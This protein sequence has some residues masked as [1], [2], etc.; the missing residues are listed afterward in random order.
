MTTSER[1]DPERHEAITGLFHAAL[2]RPATE[3]AGYLRLACGGDSDLYQEVMY[4][5]ALEESA[6][7]LPDWTAIVSPAGSSH[8]PDGER[9]KC[10]PRCQRQFPATFRLCPDDEQRLSLQ[11]PYH[12]VGRTLADKFLIEALI[13]I[14]GMG[15]V[16]S[17]LHLG[18][19]RRVAFKILQPNVALG[20]ERM[21]SLFEREAK[22][23]GHLSHENIADITDAGRTADGIAYLVMEWLDGNTLD[24]ELAAS[25]PLSLERTAEIL[26][27]IAAALDAAHARHIIHCDLKPSNIML[28]PGAGGRARVKVLDFGIAK[29]LN[30][31]AGLRVSAAMGTP[32]YASPEQFQI[33]GRIDA[34]SDIYSLGVILYQ[35]LTGTLPFSASSVHELALLQMT[36]PPSADRL[37]PDLSAEIGRRVNRMLAREPKERLDRVWDVVEAFDHLLQDRTEL[38]SSPSE[39]GRQPLRII[40]DLKPADAGVRRAVGREAARAQLQRAFQSVVAGRGSLVCVT[41]EAGIGKTTVVEEFLSQFPPGGRICTVA[42]GRCSERLEGAGAY[43]PLLESIEDLV[44]GPHGKVHDDLLRQIA[45]TWHAQIAPRDTSPA[46]LPEKKA[47][48]QEQ[49]KRELRAF[50]QQASHHRPLILFL[51]DLHWSDLSTID[52]IAFLGSK[53]D[54]TSALILVTYRPT[55][56]LLSKHPFL[57]IKLDLQARGDCR[58]IALNFFNREEIELYLAREFP[59]HGF[60]PEFSAFILEKTEGSP[61][62]VADLLRYLRDRSVIAQEGGRWSLTEAIPDIGPALPASVDGMIQRKI[63]QLSD[64]ERRLLAAASV[65]GCEFDSAVLSK[66]LAM[67]AEA[68]EELLE[69]LETVHS[70]VRLIGEQEFPDKTLTLRYRFVHSLYQNVF[71]GS[72]KPTRKASYSAAVADALVQFYGEKS[73]SIAA[74][75]ALLFE[76]AREGSRAAGHFLLAAQNASNLF[77]YREAIVLARRGLEVLKN[78]PDSPERVRQEM[79]LQIILGM[80]LI[81][82]RGYAAP[83]VERAFLRAR[84]LCLHSNESLQLFPVLRGLSLFYSTRPRLETA[85]ELGEQLLRLAEGQP[86]PVLSLEALFSL[87]SSLYFMGEFTSSLDHVEKAIA[88][89][90]PQS[91]HTGSLLYEQN[92]T[93][94]CLAVAG[95]ALW[96]LGFPDQSLKRI[97]ESVSLA[98]Q[99]AQ[100][101]NLARSFAWASLLHLLRKEW[102]LCQEQAET[103]IRLSEQYEYR[104]WLAMGK[105]YKGYAVFQQGR[106]GRQGQR[107]AGIRLMRAGLEEESATG[108]EIGRPYFLALLGEVLGLEGQVEEGLSLIDQSIA[109]VNNTAERCAYADIYRIKGELL[110]RAADQSGTIESEAADCLRHAA[111]YARLKNAK[112]L[113]L[114][115]V[116]SLSRLL[117]QQGRKDEAR[118]V[119]SEVFGWFTEGLETEDLQEAGTRLIEL[120]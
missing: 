8:S 36:P 70:F 107:E 114:R 106:Q 75:L 74:D 46:H 52:L 111:E 34:R 25:G 7:E 43:L 115:A 65:Q 23:A 11:D 62:F 1:Y 82:I 21:E 72:L 28:I 83:E 12:L 24:E 37:R 14:G 93:V 108:A 49:M 80:S 32:H 35:M 3:R 66:A 29:I 59:G 55:E 76:A 4:L 42:R 98:Q 51:D 58:E 26:R 96:A 94:G 19:D 113:E 85:R 116:M 109:V 39:A 50:I 30:D 44:R 2:E 68:V 15:A 110:L 100:P 16:Y 54:S 118:Q 31:S 105:I 22:L 90:S 87:G 79:G 73:A 6:E 104:Y 81:A 95:H 84:E 33:G 9:V 45:P 89:N 71:Y 53:F 64:D 48:S 61:L 20:N 56:M 97:R 47:A 103:A 17:A 13:G 57:Q 18:I 69:S 112:S 77:A 86:D 99:L 78:L 38:H 91:Q 120:A 88:L 40:A 41:G 60:P 117:Q 67:A 101:F 92:A 119:L 5:L 10:C 27:Q 63:N 102:E